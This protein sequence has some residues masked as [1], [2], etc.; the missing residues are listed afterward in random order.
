MFTSQKCNQSQLLTVNRFDYQTREWENSTFFPRKYGN[1]YG[2]SL[3]FVK[4]IHEFYYDIIFLELSQQNNFSLK[5]VRSDNNLLEDLMYPSNFLIN[6]AESLHRLEGF[7][8]LTH[9]TPFLMSSLHFYA[10]EGEPFSQFQ[11]MFKMFSN[12]VWAMIILTLGF[13]VTMIVV[14]NRASEKVQNFVFGAGIKT[15]FWNLLDIFLNGGQNRVPNRNFAR[16]ILILVVTW[17]LIIRTC[18][19]SLLFLFL[20]SDLRESSIQSIYEIIS[21]GSFSHLLSHTNENGWDFKLNFNSL[22]KASEP[23]NKVIAV[24]RLQDTQSELNFRSGQSSLHQLHETLL[25]FFQGLIFMNFSPFFEEFNAQIGQM[26]DTGYFNFHEWSFNYR[27]S[28]IK[29]AAENIGPQVLTMDHLGVAFI[30]CMI[31]LSMAVVAFMVEISIQTYRT[32][33]PEICFLL[34]LRDYLKT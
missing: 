19:Q 33:I 22:E 26:R 6:R 17:S 15:P 8:N 31:P 12:E 24:A 29:R 13:L 21:S 14:I 20:Q 23:S 10:P 28:V 16:F 5:Y 11:K 34:A 1:F 7:H 4:T 25:T 18:Y 2:C 3:H 27:K 32:K 30:A 9:S